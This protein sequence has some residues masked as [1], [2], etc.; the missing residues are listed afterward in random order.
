MKFYKFLILFQGRNN[1]FFTV[2]LFL[3][4]IKTTENGLLE[5]VNL[6]KTGV[7]MLWIIE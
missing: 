2:L 7:N 4:H 6:G 1:F 3:H 5:S